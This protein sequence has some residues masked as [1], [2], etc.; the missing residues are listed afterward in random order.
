MMIKTKKSNK[1]GKVVRQ[2]LIIWIVVNILLVP[3]IAIGFNTNNFETKELQKVP[4]IKGLFSRIIP[5]SGGPEISNDISQPS[6]ALLLPLYLL[7]IESFA[8]IIILVNLIIINLKQDKKMQD[9][10]LKK[11]KNKNITHEQIKD[12]LIKYGL[13]SHLVHKFINKQRKIHLLQ[14]LS[15]MMFVFIAATFVI[16]IYQQGAIFGEKE[17][18]GYAAGFGTGC[19]ERFC[20]EMSESQCF[21]EQPYPENYVDWNYYPLKSCDDV[22]SCNTGCCIDDEGYCLSNY[23]QSNCELY[24]YTFIK[25]ECNQLWDECLRPP[26]PGEVIDQT[27]VTMTPDTSILSF[28]QQLMGVWLDGNN[29]LIVDQADPYGARRLVLDPQVVARSGDT[30]NIKFVVDNYQPIKKVEIKLN[31]GSSQIAT[32]ELLDDSQHLDALENDGIF[33]NIYTIPALSRGLHR[34]SI[35]VYITNNEDEVNLHTNFYNYTIAS[36]VDCLPMIPWEDTENRRDIIFIGNN[37]TPAGGIDWFE[38]MISDK[39][40]SLISIPPFKDNHENINFFYLK[41]D[42]QFQSDSAVLAE[43]SSQC[44]FFNQSQDAAILFDYNE[45]GCKKLTYGLYRITPDSGAIYNT[46]TLDDAINNMCEIL[47]SVLDYIMMHNTQDSPPE[48][49]FLTYNERT[50]WQ[51]TPTV[52]FKI[53]DDKSVSIQY[54]MNIDGVSRLNSTTASGTVNKMSLPIG[55]GHHMIIM[56]AQDN[57]ENMNWTEYNFTINSS[58]GYKIFIIRQ[59]GEIRGS[60]LINIS[61]KIV[62]NDPSTEFRFG[63]FI[64]DERKEGGM[65]PAGAVGSVILENLEGDEQRLVI[66][67]EDPENRLIESNEI[68]FFVQGG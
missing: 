39:Y 22:P 17:Q 62:A 54:A 2:A 67:A 36:G 64:N 21:E 34:I 1:I 49:E 14:R 45:P 28:L 23:L 42:N 58:L 53:T 47:V 5:N 31:D 46:L 48:I 35:D 59:E 26:G 51:D 65:I 55:D 10:Y 43:L 30:V 50:F 7:I 32:M 52:K 4:L 11:I 57:N 60:N 68:K 44:G 37:I 38:Q 40:R 29:N 9:Y 8:L 33:G 3:V 20:K 56:F 18:I 41:K 66:K 12:H 15:M 63:I 13:D 19:C 61:F 16:V 6:N 27:G 25:K 24:D